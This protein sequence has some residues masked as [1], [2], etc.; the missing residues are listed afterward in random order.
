MEWFTALGL[1][2]GILALAI[3]LPRSAALAASIWIIR[4]NNLFDLQNH[5]WS[6]T[7]L[8]GTILLLLLL[9]GAEVA[10][11][12]DMIAIRERKIFPSL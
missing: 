2:I 11:I 7:Q 8:I 5:D 9:V 1:L 3:F 6:I 4:F 12:I 10:L